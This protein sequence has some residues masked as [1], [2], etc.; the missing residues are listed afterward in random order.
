METE[1]A[2]ASVY[3][4]VE[5]KVV[6]EK[7][8]DNVTT[9]TEL[10]S[11]TEVSTPV[12]VTL[13]ISDE[14]YA[15][16]K[17]ALDIKVYGYHTNSDGESSVIEATV[18]SSP[19]GGSTSARTFTFTVSGFSTFAIAHTGGYTVTFDA[20]GGTLSDDATYQVAKDAALNTVLTSLP[21]A[22]RSG[23]TLK[24]S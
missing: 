5:L 9:T 21:T 14:L 7:T 3:F 22:T 13:S 11:I 10:G 4:N 19:F 6:S 20:N 8:V 17:A 23:Y 18:G 16:L 1:G 24:G 15:T 2:T 12:S